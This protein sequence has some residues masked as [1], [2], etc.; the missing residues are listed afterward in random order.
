[1]LAGYRWPASEPK[2]ELVLVHGYLDHA[3]RYPEF[4]GEALRRGYTVSALDLRGHGRSAGQRGHAACFGHY[5]DDLDSLLRIGPA[6]ELPRFLVGHSM[7]ALVAIRFLQAGRGESIRGLVLS[8]PYLGLRFALPL[9]KKLL[10]SLLNRAWPTF[11]MPTDLPAE[12]LSRNHE[13]VEKTKADPL[14][15]KVAT[16]RAFSRQ[17][18]AHGEALAQADKLRLPLLL[19]AGGSDRIA[20]LSATKDFYGRVGASDKRLD[21]FEAMYHEIFGD[22]DRK[23]IFDILFPWL[24]VRL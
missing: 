6:S 17:L 20:D 18:V 21:V 7:G 15:G 9:W 22:P 23:R 19:L 8:S 12:D 1:M 2:G 11:S 13:V 4:V 24:D 3:G 5:L 10:A 16:A 14:Y